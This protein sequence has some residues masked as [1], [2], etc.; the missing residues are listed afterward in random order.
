MAHIGL[1]KALQV[2]G[3]TISAISGIGIGARVGALY[4]SRKNI[5]E[6]LIF[7]RTTP[8][9]QLFELEDVGVLDNK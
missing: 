2:Q 9:F 3:F 6:M 1:I 8:P 7:F 5:D 4:A